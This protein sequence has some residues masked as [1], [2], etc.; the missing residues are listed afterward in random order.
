MQEFI[1][2]L[3]M[4][5]IKKYFGLRPLPRNLL[6]SRFILLSKL[7]NFVINF[8]NHIYMKKF[9]ITLILLSIITFAIQAQKIILVPDEVLS[10]P[11]ENPWGLTYHNGWFWASDCENGNIV[12]FHRYADGSDGFSVIKAPRKHITG[13]TFEGDYLWVLSDEWD[14]IAFP[15]LSSQKTLLFKLDP[16]SGDVLD[17]LVIPYYFWTGRKDSLIYAENGIAYDPNRFL[18]GLSYHDS[19]LFVSYNGGW[20]SC[21]YRVETGNNHITELC[22]AHPSGM[23]TIN[24]ELWEI[25]SFPWEIIYTDSTVIYPDSILTNSDSTVVYPDGTV[26]S[27]SDPNRGDG[28]I[29]W[30]VEPVYRNSLLPL[31]IKDSIAEEDWTR[32]LEFDLYASDLTWD[33]ANFWLLDPW[34]KVVKRM[35]PD[36]VYPDTTFYCFEILELGIIP[37]KPTINDEVKV[38]CHSRFTSGGCGMTKYTV[39][40]DGWSDP[41][42]VTGGIHVN[43]YHEVGMLTYICESFDTIPIGKLNPGYQFLDYTLTATNLN[44]GAITQYLDFFVADTTHYPQPYLEIIPEKP[45]AGEEVKIVT[46][47]I[48]YI[49][50]WIDIMEHHITLYAYYNSCSMGICGIDTL[51]LGFLSE[52][53]YTLEYYLM[54]ICLPF[55]ADSLVY[56]D[57]M[58][59]DVRGATNIEDQFDGQFRIYPNPADDQLFIE[60]NKTVQN[61]NLKIYNI[62]GQLVLKRIFQN[63]ANVDLDVSGLTQGI[64]V[65]RL[66][67]DEEAYNTRV[68]IQ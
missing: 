16:N 6:A 65:M 66:S 33:G 67:A 1:R 62:T 35:V 60:L 39:E 22:C 52:D 68:I 29:P 24:G 55:P 37:E 57:L 49:N 61:L 38:V 18:M 48:C 42:G 5:M 32:E 25:R 34:E 20:G 26:S 17:T 40:M 13:L 12:K 14:T 10:I 53:S 44:C 30:P 59:F 4:K 3:Y 64:Y 2:W 56:Y 27:G 8:L 28:T 43:A 21:L 31:I 7:L 63:T 15:Y 45:V 46:H 23:E 54:D 36:T 47:G 11:T 50:T 51:S 19:S 58:E 41:S 9:Y